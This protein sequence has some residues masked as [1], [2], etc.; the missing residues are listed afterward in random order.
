MN[1]KD[2]LFK[3]QEW[4]LDEIGAEMV[5]STRYLET[6]DLDSFHVIIFVS[7]IENT[8]GIRLQLE[9]LQNKNFNTLGGLAKYIY[10]L[11][12]QDKFHKRKP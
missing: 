11:T 4:L 5:S 1:E 8:F 9:E 12:M 7:Y 10:D 3:L 2:I 6:G